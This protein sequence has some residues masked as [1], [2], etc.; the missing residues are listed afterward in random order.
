MK[1]SKI[2]ALSAIF[3]ICFSITSCN[4]QQVEQNKDDAIVLNVYK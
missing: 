4:E 2:L 3:A 1:N